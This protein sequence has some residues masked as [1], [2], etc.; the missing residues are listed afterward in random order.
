MLFTTN[1]KT[2]FNNIVTVPL[3]SYNIQSGFYF[4]VVNNQNEI[5]YIFKFFKQ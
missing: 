2:E 5:P 1:L 4:L 3:S